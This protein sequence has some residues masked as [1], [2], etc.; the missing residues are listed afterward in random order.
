MRKFF[1]TASISSCREWM[2]W[3]CFFTFTFTK[4]NHNKYELQNHNQIITNVNMWHA[5]CAHTDVIS[6]VILFP[7]E[8]PT[9]NTQEP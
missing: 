8:R 2:L 5:M 4:S 7:S 3:R 6:T 1:G 9:E